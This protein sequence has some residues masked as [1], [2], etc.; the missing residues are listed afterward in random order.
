[1]SPLPPP[2]LAVKVREVKESG[3]PDWEIGT[4]VGPTDRMQCSSS[5][6]YLIISWSN[7]T[8][9]IRTTL[10]PP[11]LG[12]DPYDNVQT[13]VGVVAWDFANLLIDHIDPKLLLSSTGAGLK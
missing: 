5:A 12:R 6:L 13:D 1:M 10:S 11:S 2:S 8:A 4:S 7:G 3:S 9:T